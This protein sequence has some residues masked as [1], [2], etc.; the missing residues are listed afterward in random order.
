MEALP[1]EKSF[2]GPSVSVGAHGAKTTLL[3]K[4]RPVEPLP[5]LLSLS[6]SLSLSPPLAARGDH[7]KRAGWQTSLSL[8]L[9]LPLTPSLPP[10]L[11]ASVSLSHSCS[12][13]V[14]VPVSCSL[15]LSLFLSLSLCLYLSV[16]VSLSLLCH[17]ECPATWGA[18]VASSVLKK[19]RSRPGPQVFGLQS[20]I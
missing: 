13:S 11:P 8:C 7:Q 4:G 2:T 12:A 18:G 16:P 3:R 6:L 9:S 20:G 15:S 14:N 10:S 17:P 5:A 1:R 19:Q